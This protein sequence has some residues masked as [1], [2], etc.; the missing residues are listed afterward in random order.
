MRARKS[1]SSSR[2]AVE[3]VERGE[4]RLQEQLRRV[5]R[6]RVEVTASIHADAKCCGLDF[7]S[8]HFIP[9]GACTDCR[10]RR[11]RYLETRPGFRM[12]RGCSG[13]GNSAW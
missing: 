8:L 5:L 7:G 4:E 3:G 13:E 9:K 6:Q 1:P 12:C 11:W 2:L 10:K